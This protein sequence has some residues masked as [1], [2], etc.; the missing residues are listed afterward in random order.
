MAKLQALI[1]HLNILKKYFYK[2]LNKTKIRVQMWPNKNSIIFFRDLTN[3]SG[4][5]KTE[6]SEYRRAWMQKQSKQTRR[7]RK[8]FVGDGAFKRS[9]DLNLPPASS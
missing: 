7:S 8:P 1:T 9:L 2:M 4:G 5:E 6:Y 3:F